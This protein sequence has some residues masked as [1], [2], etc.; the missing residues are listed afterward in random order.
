MGTEIEP[1]SK[2]PKC[3]KM[4]SR[5]STVGTLS[6]EML[7]KHFLHLAYAFW[8][9]PGPQNWPQNRPHMDPKIDPKMTQ[10]DDRNKDAIPELKHLSKQQNINTS[11]HQYTKIDKVSKFKN[12][13]ALP[14][15]SNEICASN[16]AYSRK[17]SEECK[18]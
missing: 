3:M 11:N 14:P 6:F 15:V 4:L 12:L 2:V 13:R 10:N 5:W 1:D 9:S 18:H 7:K 16:W 8:A 17:P